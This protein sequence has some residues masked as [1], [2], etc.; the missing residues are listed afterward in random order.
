MLSYCLQIIWSEVEKLVY[1][2]EKDGQINY[3]LLTWAINKSVFQVILG[4]AMLTLCSK[5]LVF[6]IRKLSE[7]IGMPSFLIPFV[8]VPVALNARMAIA[9]I[10]PA[11][12]K[13]S[14]TASLTF[15]EIYG[16]V[17]MNNI[18]GMTTLLA[19][20]WAKDLT[21][22][23]SAQVLIVLVACA[24]IGLPALFSNRYPLW[25]SLL[26]FS[27]YPSCASLLPSS[28]VKN[29]PIIETYL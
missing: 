25:T 12:Q 1:E 14:K 4:I 2:V 15:S 8:I 5:P 24:T 28:V 18:M 21:W 17:I 27:L 13:C 7:E 6:S 9:A 11:S 16:G 20:V 29:G 3:K 10:F 19:V 23:Y 22:D 26:A